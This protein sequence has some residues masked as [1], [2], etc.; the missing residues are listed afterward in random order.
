MLLNGGVR[1]C[2]LWIVVFATS[3]AFFG[4]ASPEYER[5]TIIAVERQQNAQGDS[6]EVAQYEVSVQ[7]RNV[8]Y[9]ALYT[10]PH[11]ASAIEYAP[12]ID[13]LVRAGEN[14]LKIPSK[15][16]GTL[17]LP[18][19]RKKILPRQP[20][21]DWSKAPSQYFAMKMQNLSEVLDL[22]ADQKAKIKPLAEQETG[23]VN[24]VIFSPVT[25]RKE[26]LERWEKI[27]RK[28]D[29]KMK[30]FLSQA[31]WEKLQDMRKQQKEE[32]EQL[33]EQADSNQKN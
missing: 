10:P 28:S 23:E 30:S 13:I 25:P 27:V 31:Q 33:V 24:Q 1:I 20:T 22:T 26:R 21:I 19:V 15:L 6:V 16:S 4:E 5:G 18:I 3:V 12:G 7:V 17:E 11:G 9:I 14:S 29:V 32:L 8:V 2:L